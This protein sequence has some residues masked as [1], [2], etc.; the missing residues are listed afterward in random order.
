MNRQKGNYNYLHII[1]IHSFIIGSCWVLK[2]DRKKKQET[3][4]SLPVATLSRIGHYHQ[5]NKKIQVKFTI[6]LSMSIICSHK[7]Q[8]NL[9]KFDWKHSLLVELI[10]FPDELKF[11]VNLVERILKKRINWLYTFSRLFISSAGGI[12]SNHP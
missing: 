1:F 4:I 7:C 2:R 3:H 6:L 5:W 11:S 8:I 9:R 12:S 10:V